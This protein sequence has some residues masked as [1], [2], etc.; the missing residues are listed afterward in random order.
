MYVCDC[1]T[2]SE[3]VSV[4]AP[5]YL[6]LAAAAMATATLFR[7]PFAIWFLLSELILRKKLLN[8][9]QQMGNK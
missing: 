4:S 2:V 9:L 8:E 5:L 1:V 7:G 3:S 6:C